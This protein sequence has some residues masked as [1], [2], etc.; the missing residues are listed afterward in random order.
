MVAIREYD[1]RFGGTFFHCYEGGRGYPLLMLHG[2]GPGA[3]TAS[4]WG[5]VLQPLASRYHILAIDLIGFGRS[6]QKPKEPYFDVD[7]WTR[8]AQ[9]A[10]D[11]LS[12]KGPV[13]ILGHSLSGYLVLR[14]ASRNPRI[15]KV[16]TTGAMGA[17]FRTNKAIEFAWSMPRSENDLRK[18][19]RTVSVLPA[20]LTDPLV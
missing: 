12:R 17:R 6:G 13:G 7:M 15:D 9:T 11:R 5:K 16:M 2:S 4:M 3:G 19:Y 20:K 14:L 10:L 1:V 18:L 8:Q